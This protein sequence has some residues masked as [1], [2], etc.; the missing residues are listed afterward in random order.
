M[1]AQRVGRLQG[2]S[3]KPEVCRADEA[4]PFARRVGAS[5]D[6]AR[7]PGKSDG[8]LRK[9]AKSEVNPMRVWPIRVIPVS[10]PRY[11]PRLADIQP[12]SSERRR[13]VSPRS[14][15]VYGQSR[16]LRLVAHLALATT[17]PANHS[18]W[19]AAGAAADATAR[20]PRSRQRRFRMA[21]TDSRHG[22]PIARNLLD[23]NF[24]AAAPNQAWAGDLTYI[25]TEQGWLYW[26][27]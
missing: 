2:A 12:T 11:L 5:D 21:T 27:W 20:H 6:G 9:K 26:P 4:Q 16:R 15:R 8:I 24:T 10:V 1:K 14:G 22:T 18:R 23:Q 7:H 25:P 19:H 3:G 17:A 13:V